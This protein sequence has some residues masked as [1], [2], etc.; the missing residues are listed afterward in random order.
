MK[1]RDY[2][3]YFLLRNSMYM[4]RFLPE[5]LVHILTNFL[6]PNMDITSHYCAVHLT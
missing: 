4:Y 1:P 3:K 2:I 5:Y 6:S